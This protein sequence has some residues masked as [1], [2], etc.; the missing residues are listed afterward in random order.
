MGFEGAS[1]CYQIAIRAVEWG[2]WLIGRIAAVSRVSCYR[3]SIG[4]SYESMK[5]GVGSGPLG[6]EYVEHE[7]GRADRGV[8]IARKRKRG[9]GGGRDVRI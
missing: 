1:T 8:G 7:E 3:L 5:E 6:R 9:G 4:R 2:R